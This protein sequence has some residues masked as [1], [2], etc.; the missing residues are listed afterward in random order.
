MNI[1]ESDRNAPWWIGLKSD[2]ETRLAKLRED[3]DKT[4]TAE[5]TAELR[6]R[7]KEIKRIIDA[8]SMGKPRPVLQIDDE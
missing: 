3:N 8:L 4:A 2:L 6:G 5:A 1:T 7:I